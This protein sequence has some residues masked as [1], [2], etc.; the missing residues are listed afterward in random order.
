MKSGDFVFISLS[1]GENVSNDT[2]ANYATN[3][4]FPQIFVVATTDLTNALVQDFG[5]TVTTPP[6]TPHFIISPIGTVSSLST[7]FHQADSLVE[8]L[9]AAQNS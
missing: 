8:E 4:N 1:V 6:S 9:M 2:L 5:F 7:G 3:N